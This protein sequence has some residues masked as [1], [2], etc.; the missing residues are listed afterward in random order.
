MGTCFPPALRGRT[1]DLKAETH[2]GDGGVG[3]L[4]VAE[5]SEYS[6]LYLQRDK[7][8]VMAAEVPAFG[9]ESGG[10]EVGILTFLSIRQPNHKM[11]TP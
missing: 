6:L 9:C 2:Q 1:K 4:R 3:G 5:A 11:K 8:L 10:D 7:C